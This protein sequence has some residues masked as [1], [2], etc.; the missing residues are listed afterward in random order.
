VDAR[1]RIRP[2]D[3]AE[4]IV[5]QTELLDA[6][7][8]VLGPGGLLVYA[9]CSIEEEE[10]DGQVDAFLD[11]HPDFEVETVVAGVADGGGID[12]DG[13]LRW[14]PHI[15]GFDGAFAVRMRRRR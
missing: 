14:L 11:R 15:H 5:L 9:T 6:A 13:R 4:L 3:M 8:N 12:D 10:N 7:A 2:T 1:W